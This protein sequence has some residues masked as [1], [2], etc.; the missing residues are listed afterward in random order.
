[1]YAVIRDGGR[2]YTVREGQE[3]AVDYR[4]VAAGQP[5]EF[6]D[7]LA[8]G[9][10]ATLRVGKPTLEGVRVSAEVLGMQ[11][12]PKLVV[13]KFRRR[14]NFKRRTGHRQMHTKVRI[15]GIVGV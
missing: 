3:L 11:Q 10:G 6:T 1:M 7:V 9:E 13:Q 15:T 2:Q 12:G 8:A 14:K 5:L 4:D